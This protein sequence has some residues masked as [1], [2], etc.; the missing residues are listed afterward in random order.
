MSLVHL[1]RDVDQVDALVPDTDVAFN[2]SLPESRV[3]YESCLPSFH[4]NKTTSRF[5]Q[6]SQ[7]KSRWPKGLFAWSKS[8]TLALVRTEAKRQILDL[9]KPEAIRRQHLVDLTRTVMFPTILLLMSL[10]SE[11]LEKSLM[12]RPLGSALSE[13]NTLLVT[14][15]Q[16]S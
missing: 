9:Q 12:A 14:C 3:I 16:S 10:G 5:H 1:K 2:W 6:S 15:V 7:G 11:T 8:G 13:L 4:S